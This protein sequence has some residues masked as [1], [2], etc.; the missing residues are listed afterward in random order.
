M[1]VTERSRSHSYEIRKV[2]KKNNMPN[3]YVYILECADGTFYTGSTIK[4]EDRIQQHQNGHGANHTKKRLPVKL[5][6]FEQFTRIDEAFKREK[7]LQGWSRR[8]KIALIE[9]NFKDLSKHSECMNASNYKD[10]LRLRS[11]TESRNDKRNE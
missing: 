9:R 7:Q 6:Y 3:G 1:L 5:I 11:A 4:L 8:K 2:K 10:W